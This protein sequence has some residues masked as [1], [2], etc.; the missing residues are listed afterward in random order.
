MTKDPDAIFGGKKSI[1]PE[2]PISGEFEIFVNAKAEIIIGVKVGVVGG[3]ELTANLGL[4]QTFHALHL[5]EV[6][7]GENTELCLGHKTTFST[8]K[9]ALQALVTKLGLRATNVVAEQTDI[10]GASAEVAASHTDITGMEDR[11]L[12]LGREIHGEQFSIG[13][14]VQ[15]CSAQAAE[16]ATSSTRILANRTEMLAEGVDMLAGQVAMAGQ[17]VQMDGQ[18]TGITG[19]STSISVMTVVV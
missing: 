5:L 4:T 12:A 16:A 17:R 2:I 6:L 3:E 11:V 8:I 13:A 10:E 18:E 15:R 7:V 9:T 19:N 14:A 1:S